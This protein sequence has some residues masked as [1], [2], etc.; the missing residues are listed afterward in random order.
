[1][2]RCTLINK[3]LECLSSG[4][5]GVAQVGL[6]KATQPYPD[7]TQQAQLT[8]KLL[9][10][11]QASELQA[12]GADKGVTYG[13]SYNKN[14]SPNSLDRR[15]LQLQLEIE[16]EDADNAQLL[17]RLDQLI[18]QC[19][20]LVMVDEMPTYWQHFIAEK[21]DF[22]FSHQVSTTLAK[23]QL[24]WAFYYQVEYPD[25]PAGPEVKEVYLGPKGGEYKLISKTVTPA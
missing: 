20:A 10:E 23:A 1:M 3:V 2:Q 7:L 4:L 15:V 8:V 17:Q 16:L 11:R 9:G 18:S 24:D 13:P 22:T 14:L 5:Q 25:D 21:S 19:E 6:L 12:K